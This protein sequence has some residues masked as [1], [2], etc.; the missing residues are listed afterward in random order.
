MAD[1]PEVGV[2][3]GPPSRT[4]VDVDP[5]TLRVVGGSFDAIAQ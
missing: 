2:S 3:P 5:I 4:R 1:L